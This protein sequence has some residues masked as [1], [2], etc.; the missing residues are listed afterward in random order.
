MKYTLVYGDGIEREP[1]GRVMPP[2]SNFRNTP[3]L[4]HIEIAQ[5]GWVFV[6]SVGMMFVPETMVDEFTIFRAFRCELE[7]NTLNL[8]ENDREKWIGI[9][10]DAYIHISEICLSELREYLAAQVGVG[11]EG[12]MDKNPSKIRELSVSM[13]DAFLTSR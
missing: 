5:N 13:L 6:V 7:D 2:G 12:E 9:L 11:L 8:P 4:H 10:G 3:K 1:L